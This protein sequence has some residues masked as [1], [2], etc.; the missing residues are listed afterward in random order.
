M[1]RR[2]PLTLR[3]VSAIAVGSRRFTVYPID[4]SW[5][6]DSEVL[7]IHVICQLSAWIRWLVPRVCVGQP[8]V[9][10]SAYCMCLILLI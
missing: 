6:R 1:S 9:T 10:V 8:L 2:T 3:P 4:L 7:N 5:S